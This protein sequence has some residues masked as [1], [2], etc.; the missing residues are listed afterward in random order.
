MSVALSSITAPHPSAAGPLDPHSA[1]LLD[2]RREG[3]GMPRVL[4]V[5]ERLHAAEMARIW[6][7]GWLFA[8]FEIEIPKAGDFLTLTVAGSPVLVIRGDDGRVRAFHNVC[9]HRGSQICRTDTG[10]VRALVC[11]YH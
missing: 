2:G 3:F 10:H 7:K 11:P 8:G 6:H 9:R 1:A 5:D 4:Y